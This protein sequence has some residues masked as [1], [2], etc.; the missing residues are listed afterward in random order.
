[1]TK[2]TIHKNRHRSSCTC[3]LD[4]VNVSNKPGFNGVLDGLC[5][6]IN[7]LFYIKN[8]NLYKTII[9]VKRGGETY[10]SVFDF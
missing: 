1:M 3:S 4:T 8:L 6:Y 9:D 2:I 7:V 10:T 5:R